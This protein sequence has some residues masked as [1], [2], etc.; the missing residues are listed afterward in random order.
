MRIRAWSVRRARR[1]VPEFSRH[2][3]STILTAACKA[4]RLM[5]QAASCGVR[6]IVEAYVDP[7][8]VEPRLFSVCTHLPAGLVR[9]ARRGAF[10]VTNVVTALQ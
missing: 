7:Y 8:A 5:E 3:H 6:T 1:R 2:V 4:A 10:A 9:L